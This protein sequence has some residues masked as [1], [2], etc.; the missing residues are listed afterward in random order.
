[1]SDVEQPPVAPP[2]KRPRWWLRLTI[3]GCVLVAVCCLGGTLFAVR[4]ALEVGAARAAAAGYLDA[5]FANDDATALSH[6]CDADR[7]TS[8]HEVFARHVHDQH[9]FGYEIT[10]TTVQS[11]N[12]SLRA[13]AMA[14]LTGQ[15][16][17]RIETVRLPLTKQ[18]GAWKV[19]SSR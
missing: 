7:S 12:V 18:G 8:S 14:N 3:I 15:G 9:A 11:W 17:A 2:A 5:V 4:P 13:T 10:N 16:G 1:V 19:C 6:V